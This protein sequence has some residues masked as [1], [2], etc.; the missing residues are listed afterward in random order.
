M[1]VLWFL[2]IKKKIHKKYYFYLKE[3]VGVTG[4][5]KFKLYKIVYIGHKAF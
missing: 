5:M 1:V 3:E 4:M 2:V